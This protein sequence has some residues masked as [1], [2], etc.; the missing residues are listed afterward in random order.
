MEISSVSSTLAGTTTANPEAA[1]GRDAF[2]KLLITQLRY[3]DPLSPMENEAF[4]AQLAQFSS[5]EQMQQLN[6]S[7][8]ASI[9]LS[10]SQANSAA[11]SLIGRHVRA[12]GDHVTLP[13]EGSV[14]LGYYLASAAES[15]EIDVVD[16]NGAVVRHLRAAGVPQ[17]SNL[18]RW[19]GHDD[20][21]QRLDA[22][23]YSFRVQA[24]DANG[25]AL[26]AA[27]TV[28]GLVSGVTF[29]SGSAMLLIDGRKVP[30]SSVLEVFL[31]SDGS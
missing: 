16:A 26:A 14:E 24:F 12:S 15:V 17:G 4:L 6:A 5:V 18:L 21:G 29:E 19:D 28:S 30:L 22:G 1:L 31:P 13:A 9:A 20:A 3:Q 8:E 10:Q 25:D 27:T 23:S 2:L 11:T 7:F